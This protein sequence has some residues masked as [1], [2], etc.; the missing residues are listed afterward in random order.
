MHR[1]VLHIA[2]MLLVFLAASPLMAATPETDP[3][4]IEPAASAS[5]PE[6]G[7]VSGMTA[8][9]LHGFCQQTIR[10]IDKTPDAGDNYAV[11]CLGYVQGFTDGYVMGKH[12]ETTFCLPQGIKGDEIARVFVKKMD[13]LPPD[14]KDTPAVPLLSAAL[15]EE[16]PCGE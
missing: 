14:Q 9:Q 8:G 10:A 12:S 2:F 4:S 11:F 3:A 7:W 13:S 15:Q 6:K 1:S 5:V 16:F